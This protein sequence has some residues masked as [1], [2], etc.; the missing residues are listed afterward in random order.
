MIAF[1]TYRRHDGLA[2]A[3]LVRRGAE[4]RDRRRWLTQLT[5]TPRHRWNRG[6]AASSSVAVPG[7]Q[8]RSSLRSCS[9]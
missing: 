8:N 6:R 7:S 9:A 1:E 4:T 3:E 5:P 2:L